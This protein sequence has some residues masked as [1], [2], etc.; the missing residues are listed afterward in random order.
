VTAVEVRAREGYDATLCETGV[1]VYEVDQTPFRR[2]PI[3]LHAAQPD[4][5]P[6]GPDCAGMW[7]APFDRA[8]GER[9]ALR[10][11]GL[12]VEVLARLPDGS[13]RLRVAA[14]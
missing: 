7:N 8:A 13:Y 12:R 9:R 3:R 14:R 6:P 11:A 10:L 5:S 1:L 4:R 2:S